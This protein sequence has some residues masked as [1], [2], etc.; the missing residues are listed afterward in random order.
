MTRIKF[1]GLTKEEEIDYV[2]DL[3]PEYIGFVF[4]KKSRRYITPEKAAGLK[5]KLDSHILA[6]GVFTDEAPEMVAELLST[7]TIDIAQL[8]GNE[9]EEYIKQLRLLTDKPMIKA[10]PIS[11]ANDVESARNSSADF[12]L[13]D[14]GQG[15]SGTAFD[16]NLIKDFNRLFYL[17]GG[18]RA[19]NVRNAVKALKPYA[20]DVSSGI[21]TNGRKDKEKMRALLH[22]VRGKDE[23]E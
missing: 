16:W 23:K 5:K 12:V 8:H 7:G 6:V 18:L 14:A 21:E 2:N 11:S 3:K 4:A 22:A 17:A 13:L 10:F 20:V 19:D 1:C 9:T 15:G